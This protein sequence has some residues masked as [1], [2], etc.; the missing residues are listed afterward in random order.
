LGKVE[1]AALMYLRGNPGS[2]A[3]QV[4]S[5]LWG[6]GGYDERGKNLMKSLQ[7]LGAVE[8]IWSRQK[9]N[10]WSIRNG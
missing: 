10:L 7:A 1:R 4:A 6:P 8:R 9:T 3:R 5:A 2:T